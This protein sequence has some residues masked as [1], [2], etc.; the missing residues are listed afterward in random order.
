MLKTEV[1][2]IKKLYN[3]RNCAVTR[4]CGC[5]VD[6][7]KNVRTTFAENFLSIPEEIMFKYLE[8]FKKSLSGT[9]DKNLINFE[10]PLKEEEKN[11]CQFELLALRDSKLKNDDMLQ[12]FY[13][14]I[15]NTYA[16]VGNYLILLI[17]NAYDVPG[18]TCDKN[19]LEDASDEVYEY[20]SCII[21]PVSLAK[22]GLAYNPE[23][24]KFTNLERDWI[25]GKPDVSFTFPA[26]N[27]RSSDIHSVLYYEKKAELE[28]EEI[29]KF[30]LGCNKGLTATEQK[31]AFG[32]LLEQCGCNTTEVKDVYEALN[33]IIEEKGRENPDI[34][35]VMDKPEVEAL[36]RKNINSAAMEEFDS[37]Y[38]REIGETELI[39]KNIADTKKMEIKNPDVSI[40]CKPDKA[41]LISEREID[42]VKCLVIQMGSDIEINGTRISLN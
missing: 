22:A 33:E 10:F 3:I 16:Y 4:I 37:V 27:D 13:D 17:H 25:V 1:N 39:A 31:A 12:A 32:V 14:K 5:Y 28:H 19:S 36:L 18:K 9:I 41:Q 7:E 2:E 15:I 8:I 35:I 29:I 38:E 30:I 20:I 23:E 34:T 40:K 21:C 24:N 11:G 42:G 26:F 6:G